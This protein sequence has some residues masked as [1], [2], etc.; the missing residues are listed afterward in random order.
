[1]NSRRG[2]QTRQGSLAAQLFVL[3]TVPKSFGLSAD[4]LVAAHILR[5]STF[6]IHRG[7]EMSAGSAH[8]AA[9]S[10]QGCCPA[11]SGFCPCRQYSFCRV[12]QRAGELDWRAKSDVVAAALRAGF[13]LL[14]EDESGTMRR[15]AKR[16]RSSGCRQPS[17]AVC[18]SLRISFFSHSFDLVECLSWSCPTGCLH[19]CRLANLPQ[20]PPIRQ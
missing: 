18:R 15:I 13:H 4:G 6:H 7:A 2:R 11:F 14:P 1:M 9:R 19:P 12:R 17:G 5:R 8:N 10:F 20:N 3:L 16:S